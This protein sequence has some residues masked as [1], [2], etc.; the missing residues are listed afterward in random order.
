[1]GLLRTLTGIAGMMNP[2]LRHALS[3]TSPLLSV[4]RRVKQL[5]A[6]PP[7]M[8]R[9]NHVL[10][11]PDVSVDEVVRLIS[12]DQSLTTRILKIVNSAY[13][14]LQGQIRL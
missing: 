6:L 3:P 7:V 10:G 5:P 1:M 8:A 4:I 13:Y 2:R 9:F 11:D 12:L 14:G